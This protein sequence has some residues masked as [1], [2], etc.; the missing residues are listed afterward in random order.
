[1]YEKEAGRHAE[2]TTVAHTAAL[3]AAMSR[4]GEGSRDHIDEGKGRRRTK[5]F[6]GN[7]H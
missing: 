5:P 3:A 7:P 4:S 2:T 1:M 6:G